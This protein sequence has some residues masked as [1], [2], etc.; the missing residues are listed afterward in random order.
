MHIPIKFGIELEM[1]NV[2]SSLY[3]DKLDYILSR[4]LSCPIDSID[5]ILH[6]SHTKYSLGKDGSGCVELRTPI[7]KNIK[8]LKKL[9]QILFYLSK[10]YRIQRFNGMHIHISTDQKYKLDYNNFQKD[11]WRKYSKNIWPG[12]KKY[13]RNFTLTSN[14]DNMLNALRG[15]V[16]KVN[17]NHAEVRIFNSTFNFKIIEQRVKKVIELYR[18]N[19]TIQ[20]LSYA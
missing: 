7:Y 5:R 15:C 14:G 17:G 10:L 2:V 6:K 9:E 3:Y 1:G 4:F 13:C 12:R 8:Q 18:K 11:I 20:K 16:Y 19:V